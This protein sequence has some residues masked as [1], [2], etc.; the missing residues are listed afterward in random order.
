MIY[1]GRSLPI[2]M[3]F[4]LLACNKNEP[5]SL[6]EI[7]KDYLVGTG[8]ILTSWKLKGLTIDSQPQILTGSQLIYIKKYLSTAYKWNYA[9]IQ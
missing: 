4:L 2:L 5:K 9:V 3:L 7:K 1:K 8:T 6:L